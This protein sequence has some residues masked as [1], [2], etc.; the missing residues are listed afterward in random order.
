MDDPKNDE[1]K[2]AVW[3]YPTNQKRYCVRR[4]KRDT[5]DGY[6]YATN[7]LGEPLIYG[8]QRMAAAVARIR[9]KETSNE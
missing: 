9:N 1:W 2:D 5:Y 3:S 7:S 4:Q 8:D 6:E